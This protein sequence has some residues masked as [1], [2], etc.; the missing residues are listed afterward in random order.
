MKRGKSC[1][2]ERINDKLIEIEKY[3]EELSEIMPNNFEEYQRNFE[4][5]AACER[6]FEKIIE[7]VIDLCF[8]LAKDR[9]LK[10][11]EDEDNIFTILFQEKIISERLLKNLKDAKGMRNFIIHQYGKINDELV[12]EAIKEKLINDIE[13]F[14]NFIEVLIR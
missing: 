5:K 7:S 13:E 1:M 10:M 14:I 4:K 12:F 9:N 11:P 2:N 8:I 3:L 6:Y